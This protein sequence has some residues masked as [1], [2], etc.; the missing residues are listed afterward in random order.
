M[1]CLKNI[2]TKLN[3][4]K[5]MKKIS[6]GLTPLEKEENSLVETNKEEIIK[7]LDDVFYN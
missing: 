5:I 4:F 6:D 2:H 7:M 3:T 1:Q